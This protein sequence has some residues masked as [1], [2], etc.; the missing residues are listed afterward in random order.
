MPIREADRPGEADFPC[1]IRLAGP[2]TCNRCCAALDEVPC[3]PLS[4][5]R[6]V[7]IRKEQSQPEVGAAALLLWVDHVSIGFDC[8]S[9]VST[10]RTLKYLR[11][12]SFELVVLSAS[13]A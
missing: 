1:A 10:C 6:E 2:L 4:N 7:K 8:D 9:C 12:G 11:P 3:E 5:R 13:L